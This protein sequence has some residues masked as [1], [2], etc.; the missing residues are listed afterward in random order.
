LLQGSQV[1]MRLDRWGAAAHLLTRMPLS[2][3]D[4]TARGRLSYAL[5][6]LHRSNPTTAQQLL[7][8]VLATNHDLAAPMLLELATMA[9]RVQDETLALDLL[10][11]AHSSATDAPTQDAAQKM[12][13]LQKERAEGSLYPCIAQLIDAARIPAEGLLTLVPV[14]G[15]YLD[16]WALWIAQVRQ[17]IGGTVV[18]LALDDAAFEHLHTEANVAVLDARKF[19]AWKSPGALHDCSRGTLWQVRTLILRDLLLRGRT[20]L[21]LDLD[22]IVL[23]PAQPIFDAVPEADI[24]AQEDHSIPMDVNRKLGFILCCGFMLWRPT[25]AAQALVERFAAEVMIERDDQLALNHILGR[26]G[27]RAKSHVGGSMRFQSAGAHIACPDPAQVSRTLHS[28]TV[29]RHFQQ[30]GHTVPQLRQE[31]GI[32][33]S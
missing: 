32:S 5:L 11:R 15:P 20:V 2:T 17:H 13:S 24:I 14:G 8:H 1:L 28:G 33:P 3:L 21:V 16:L 27:I 25:P 10:A 12:L 23:A 26:E 18:A 9:I 31:L 30:E 22:A 19:F 6:M 4:A 7:R 29:V